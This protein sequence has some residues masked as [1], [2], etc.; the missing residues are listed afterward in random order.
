MSDSVTPICKNAAFVK[1][2]LK[3]K[4]KISYGMQDGF[5]ICLFSSS[6]FTAYINTSPL[7]DQ[8]L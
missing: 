4:K 3:R 1:V 2:K 6:I 5:K 8:L 7:T